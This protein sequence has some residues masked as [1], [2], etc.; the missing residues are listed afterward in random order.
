MLNVFHLTHFLL[1]GRLLQLVLGCAVN[2]SQKQVYIESIMS[3]EESVQRVI[4][5]A[6]QVGQL[7]GKRLPSS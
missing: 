5:E 3:M 6:I 7:D 1:L 4:M 2:C